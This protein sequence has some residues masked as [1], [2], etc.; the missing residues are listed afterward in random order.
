[1][2]DLALSNGISVKENETVNLRAGAVVQFIYLFQVQNTGG[3]GGGGDC[4]NGTVRR[5]PRRWIRG[6][7]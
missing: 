1:M 5:D 4:V 3:L 7:R 6:L 2:Q